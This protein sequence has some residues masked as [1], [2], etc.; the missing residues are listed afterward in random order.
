MS[1][2]RIDEENQIG[3]PSE[4]TYLQINN[5]DNVQHRTHKEAIVV[6]W[7]VF[8]GY[9]ILVSFQHKLKEEMNITDIDVHASYI[10]SSGIS[11]LYFGNLLF[12]LLHNII[13]GFVN[14]RVR[15]YI[16]MISMILSMM[17]ISVCIFACKFHYVS[18]V[19]ISYL[20][21]GISIGSFESNM[22]T[23]ITPLGHTTKLWAI[24]GMPVGFS[25][26][27]IGGFVLSALNVPPISIY[28]GVLVFIVLGI[29]VFR[30]FIPVCQI[31]NNCLTIVEFIQQLREFKLWFSN[32]WINSVSLL[33]DMFCV[34]TFTS[35]MLYVF[36]GTNV[37]L[38]MQNEITMDKNWYFV[39]FNSCSMF[40]DIS[41]R[42]LAYVV[43]K[44]I[45]L[46][47]QYPFL[48]LVFSAIGIAGCLTKTGILSW[49]GIYLI[50]HANGFIYASTTRHIDENIVN[51]YNLISLS[52]WLFVGDIGSVV[53]SNVIEMIKF[54]ICKN[55]SPL[56]CISQA[57]TES[58]TPLFI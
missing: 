18:L 25:T 30:I 38:F 44:K 58:L 29:I 13:F 46:L 36:D 24:V 37:P 3:Y 15:V 17:I 33:L 19:W 51:K 1:E 50:M 7:S 41:G 10:F 16:S 49:F 35:L 56:V 52:V 23:S 32:I 47:G 45:K 57:V 2:M 55:S 27:L 9:G 22:I 28:I 54:A 14:S 48:W 40:G 42:T 11:C 6:V 8:M 53:G 43:G 5:N 12:R 39:V 20:L 31:Q 26:I 21:G 34:G 4:T